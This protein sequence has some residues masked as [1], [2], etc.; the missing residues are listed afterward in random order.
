MVRLL[1]LRTDCNSSQRLLKSANS[2]SRADFS[3]ES[4]LL[5]TSDSLESLE[6]VLSC[7]VILLSGVVARELDLEVILEAVVLLMLL[8]MTWRR[9]LVLS[10]GGELKSAARY[11]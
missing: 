7:L 2:D 10:N 8:L 9:C 5:L 3:A 6:T 11:V 1:V 4:F